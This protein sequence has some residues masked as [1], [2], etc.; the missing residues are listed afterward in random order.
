M[1]DE[2]IDLTA[3]CLC[4]SHVYSTN[5]PK[6]S[7][8]LKAHICHCSSCRHVTGSLCTSIVWPSPFVE[9]INDISSLKRYR[10]SP[11]FDFLFCPT[12]STPIFGVFDDGTQT[13]GVLTGC[14]NNFA[15]E[16]V[17][18]VRWDDM[19]FVGDTKDG[20]ASPWLRNVNATGPALKC[21]SG[22][23]YKQDAIELP[24][25]WPKQDQASER[26]ADRQDSVP[27]HCKCQGVDL[28]LHRGDYKTMDAKDLPWNVDAQT[29]KIKANLCGC[30]SCRLQSGNDVFNW[31]F[32]ELKNISYSTSSSGDISFPTHM[33]DLAALVDTQDER[34]GSLRYYNS[35]PGIERYFCGTCSATVFFASNGRPSIVDVAVGV[36]D[37]SDGAR[38][39]GLLAWSLEKEVEFK[40]DAKGG[41]REGL[42][43]R[44]ERAARDYA[45]KRGWST[46]H[47]SYIVYD[48]AWQ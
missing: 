31:T 13:T 4:N 32:V 14:L 16:G 15:A 25:D 33:D 1:V 34:I 17:E 40:G 45:E 30:N 22:R 27:I 5:L 38:A 11:D 39:E 28:Y 35:S 8:P 18:A 7:L 44:V 10:Y 3:S 2:T 20:G 48:V 6:S 19:G 36:L 41:W 47:D 23:T 12:C 43:E 46:Y 26:A 21:F 29:R 24:E 37:A 9:S 42:L